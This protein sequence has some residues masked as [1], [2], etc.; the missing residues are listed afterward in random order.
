MK[1]Q[2]LHTVW[3]SISGEAA[4]DIWH[5]SLTGLK[6]LMGLQLGK[7]PHCW[8]W[9]Q[10]VNY[11]THWNHFTLNVLYVSHVILN[12]CVSLHIC[13]ENTM[14]EEFICG[15]VNTWSLFFQC[16]PSHYYLKLL[17]PYSD[18]LRESSCVIFLVI[19]NGTPTI[20]VNYCRYWLN[21]VMAPG[22]YAIGKDR[23]S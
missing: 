22:N 19:M 3:H 5:W 18:L 12:F 9:L 14:A 21:L 7:V 16:C 11:W 13:H 20:S 23:K 17:Y 2:V 10:P 4:G 15:S 8:P 6:G 1:S